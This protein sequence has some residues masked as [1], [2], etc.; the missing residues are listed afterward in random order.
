MK[1]LL[2][3]VFAAGGLAVATPALAQGVYVGAG[4][5][6]VGVGVDAG[7]RYHDSYRYRDYDDDYRHRTYGSRVIVHEARP[8]CRTTIIRDEVGVR[9]TIRRCW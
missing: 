7:P 3:A 5:G 8:R 6:G 2:F 4:P 9:K 1:K